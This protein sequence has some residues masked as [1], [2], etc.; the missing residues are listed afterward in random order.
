MTLFYK[1][2]RDQG[3]RMNLKNFCIC[4]IVSAVAG[5]ATHDGRPPV[6]TFDSPP[7]LKLKSV[8]HWETVAGHLAGKLE[9]TLKAANQPVY[10]PEIS[11]SPFGKVFPSQLRSSLMQMGIPI[12]SSAAGALQ[13]NVGVQEVRHVI[14]GGLKPGELTALGGSL[15]YLDTAG[16]TGAALGGALAIA[17]AV[18]SYEKHDSRPTTEVTLT[19]T[20]EQN[21]VYTVYRTDT[22]Y[23]DGVD[24]SLFVDRSR[25][26]PVIQRE[27]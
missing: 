14:P 2:V 11:G 18:F 22:Y 26:F 21:G 23:I 16:A 20:I 6:A 8:K 15:W 25:Q 12:G 3:Q 5:C 1:W 13:V 10:I 4:A 17:D 27:R 7:E 19:T 9:P 24:A